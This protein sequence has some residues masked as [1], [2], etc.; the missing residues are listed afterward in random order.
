MRAERQVN[1]PK[2]IWKVSV[3]KSELDPEARWWQKLFHG[4]IYLPFQDFSFGVM[5]IPTTKEVSVESDANGN[6][7]RTYHWFEDV[8][9]FDTVEEADANCLTERYGYTCYTHG[10]LMPFR[11]AQT[12]GI[13]TVFPR[14]KDG[15]R[16]AKPRLLAVI[17]DRKED[18]E[19]HLVLAEC[20]NQINRTLE[21]RR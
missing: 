7:R 16:W 8:G 12:S 14:R 9:T 2:K 4:Y 10:Q 19:E 17:K 13:G 5:K 3:W 11:S 6:I 18:E 20:L 15:Q 21:P 1:V